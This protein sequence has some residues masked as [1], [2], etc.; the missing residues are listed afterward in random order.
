MTEQQQLD[1][2]YRARSIAAALEIAYGD[3]GQCTTQD[4]G[5]AVA[6]HIMGGGLTYCTVVDACRDVCYA[7]FADGQYFLDDAKFQAAVAACK[8]RLV[9]SGYIR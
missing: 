5:R 3:R 9:L 1:L 2:A 7:V 8:E 4:V 6:G